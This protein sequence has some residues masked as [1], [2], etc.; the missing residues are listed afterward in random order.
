M[1]SSGNHHI[2]YDESFKDALSGR[3]PAHQSGDDAGAMLENGE[4]SMIEKMSQ[5][6]LHVHST[7]SDG[8]Y[9]P[10]QLV[11]YAI[12]KG[13]S[14]FALTDHDTVSGLE[15]AI[16]YAKSSPNPPE[17]VPGIELSSEYQGRDIHVVGLDIDY[18]NETF[19]RYLEDFIASRDMRNEKMCALLRERGIDISMEALQ[20]EFPGA[21]IT[22]AHVARHLLSHGYTK[23]I[24]EAFDR[25]VGDHCPCFVPREKVTA[26]QAVELILAADGIPVLAH[27]ILYHMSEERLEV[28]TR[29]LKDAGLIGI[30]AIYSTYT[31]SD[32]GQIRRLAKKLDLTISGGSDFHGANKPSIDLGVGKGHLFVPGEVLI[33]LRDAK[34]SAP[35]NDSF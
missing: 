19:V 18:T 15:R 35:F 31:T 17:I 27:P 24:K 30:E 23:S 22:R 26:R 32:E 21:V 10:E 6:D 29:E 2:S 13:L 28:L 33:N 8:T 9:T 1:Y 34:K 12:E 5:I 11:D 25:Y 14:A 3:S 4:Y 7:C 16:E 20:E